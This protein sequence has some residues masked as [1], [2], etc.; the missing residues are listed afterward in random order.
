MNRVTHLA[1][2]V[3]SYLLFATPLNANNHDSLIEA[4][5]KEGS[6]VLYTSM[7]VDQAQKLNDAFRV[8][9]PFLQVHM[10]RAVGERLLTKIM[11]ETQ[12]GRSKR[13]K[14]SSHPLAGYRLA[15]P[16]RPP[17]RVWKS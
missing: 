2:C 4:A 15:A 17:S 10:F 8:K 3:L 13:D 1:L 7:T 16:C 14:E 11:T 5:K 12:A 6:L 9:Y